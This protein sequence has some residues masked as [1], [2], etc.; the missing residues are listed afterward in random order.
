MSEFRGK[1]IIAIVSSVLGASLGFGSNFVLQNRGAAAAREEAAR[2]WSFDLLKEEYSARKESYLEIKA[3]LQ[4]VEATGDSE[5]I[6]ALNE[7]VFMM[8]I[9][10]PRFPT[11]N[12]LLQLGQEFSRRL[13]AVSGDHEAVKNFV[14][15]ESQKYICIMDVNLSAIERLLETIA[16]EDELRK[17]HDEPEREELEFLGRS[18]FEDVYKFNR[19]D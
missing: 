3:A 1:L 17:I 5:A 10:E 8:P 15:I 13:E 18:C 11:N 14:R 2:L 16:T 9:L 4:R 12:S 19:P 7:A 6:E